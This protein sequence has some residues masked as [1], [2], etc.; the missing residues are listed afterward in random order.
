MFPISSEP[1]PPVSVD[2]ATSD[3]NASSKSVKIA[4]LPPANGVA[5]EYEVT[6]L[7][8][9]ASLDSKVTSEQMAFLENSTMKNGYVYDVRI[10]S[11]SEVF[12][13]DSH[14]VS[15]NLEFKIKTD[16]QG[17][18]LWVLLPYT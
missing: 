6:L 8:G 3:F 5:A 10:K 9:Q 12:D 16:V 2:N 13:G 1:E 14:E 17:K 15:E 11:R 18:F 4:W 7:D